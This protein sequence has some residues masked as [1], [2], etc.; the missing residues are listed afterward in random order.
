MGPLL[1]VKYSPINPKSGKGNQNA[2]LASIPESVFAAVVA[3]ANYD[4]DMLALGGSNSLTYQ[5]IIERL[6]DLAEQQIS[7]DTSL[8]STTRESVIGRTTDPRQA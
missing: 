1:P 5:A 6:D 7:T 3:N 4:R 8:E 2:Y